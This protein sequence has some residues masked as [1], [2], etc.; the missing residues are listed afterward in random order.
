MALI[1]EVILFSLVVGFGEQSKTERQQDTVTEFTSLVDASLARGGDTIQLLPGNVVVLPQLA[2]T[3]GT[4]AGE[5]PPDAETVTTETDRWTTSLSSAGQS[6]TE[7]QVPTRDLEPIHR[8]I[9]NESINL[10]DR[11]LQIFLE[12]TKQLKV[13]VQLDG[14]P[15]EELIETI[16][17][18]IPIATGIF[19]A[20]YGQLL[21]VRRRVGL[22]TSTGIPEGGIPGAGLPGSQPIIPPIDVPVGEPDTG[23]GGGNGGGNGGGGGGQG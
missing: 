17:T 22:S 20:G 18:Q 3:I 23:G 10:M 8:L 19:Q 15:R 11:G 5:D 21:D 4:L 7:L 14:A 12:I 6:I 1:L 13:V 9:L 16:Q 2:T